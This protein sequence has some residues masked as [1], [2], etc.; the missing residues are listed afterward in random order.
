MCERVAV[1]FAQGALGRGSDMAKDKAGCGLGGD[2]L[3]V[4]AV[5]GGNGRCEKAG[6]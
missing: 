4:G 1:V 6:R 5:P 3:Q 2:T